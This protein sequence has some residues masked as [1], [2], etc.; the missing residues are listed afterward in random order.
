MFQSLDVSDEYIITG[1]YDCTAKIWSKESQTDW[2][3]LHVIG[4]H[5]DSIWDLRLR[6]NI[7]VTG[8]LDGAIGIFDVANRQMQV[9]SFFQVK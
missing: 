4:L 3:Q 5:N 7:L 6:D 2:V 8:G 9:R 1:S